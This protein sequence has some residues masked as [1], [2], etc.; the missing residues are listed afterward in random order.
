[1]PFFEYNGFLPESKFLSL[2]MDENILKDIE[3]QLAATNEIGNKYVKTELIRFAFRWTI[4]AVL[5][6]ILWNKIP[7]L[8]WSLLLVIPVA[9]FLLYKIYAEKKRLDNQVKDIQNTLDEI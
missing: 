1:M 6:L 4:I 2:N 9:L 5:Y 3:D 7:Y 8:K